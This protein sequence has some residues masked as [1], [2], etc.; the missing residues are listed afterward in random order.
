M[1]EI[2]EVYLMVNCSSFAENPE[3]L[4]VANISNETQILSL[5]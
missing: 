2:G 5:E 4:E 1:T 3:H